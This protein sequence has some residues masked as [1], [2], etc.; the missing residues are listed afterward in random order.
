MGQVLLTGEE[1]HERSSLPGSGIAHRAAQH[2]ELLL[3]CVQDGSLS[4]RGLNLHLAVA[5]RQLAQMRRQ[6]HPD[7]DSVCAST[8]N[9]AGR[10]RTMGAQLSPESAEA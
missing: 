4:G 5:A 3:Y 6:H 10:S 2:R 9:T 1:A 8:D 7:H